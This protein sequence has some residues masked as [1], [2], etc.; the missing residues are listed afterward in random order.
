MGRLV[1]LNH[2]SNHY[3]EK[4]AGDGAFS[5]L[6]SMRNDGMKNLGFMKSLDVT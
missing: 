2:L 4:M 6:R 3:P 1:V 5:F